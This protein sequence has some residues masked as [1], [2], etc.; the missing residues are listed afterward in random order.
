M[1]VTTLRRAVLV[2]CLAGVGATAV[3]ATAVLAQGTAPAARIKQIRQQIE[4]A[5]DGHAVITT[6]SQIQILTAAAT[7]QLS[8]VPVNYDATLQTAEVVEAYTLKANG[9]KV[10][11]DPGNI[12]TQK[13]AQASSLVPIY[14]NAEQKMVLFP[15]VEAGDTLVLT[16]RITETKP[17]LSGQYTLSHYFSPTVEADDSVYT[18]SAPTALHL[19]TAFSGVKQDVS[20]EGDRTIYRW[21]LS[22]IAT[23]AAPANLV[24]D[25]ASEAHF[26]VS[27]F[28]DYDAFVHDYAQR[29]AG[30]VEATPPVARQADQL[31]T[32]IRDKRDQARALYQWMN[33]NVRYVAIEFGVGSVIPHDPDWTLNNGFGDCK[34][35]AVLFASMLAAKGIKAELVLI[36]ATNRYTLTGTPTVGEFN[37]MIVYLPEFNLYADTTVPGL[38]FGMLPL[39][40]YGRPVMHVVDSGPAQHKTPLLAAGQ[41]TSTYK[42]HA[43]QNAQG[44][45]DADMNV[46]ATGP[47]AGSL[48]RIGGDIS[49]L[50]GAAAAGALLKAHGFPNATGTLDTGSGSDAQYILNGTYH[51][52]R[53]NP[54]ANLVNIANGLYIL[55]RAGDFL[56][57]PLNNKT[58]TAGDATPCFSGK[59]IE[60]ISFQF[61]GNAHLQATPADVHVKTASASYDSHWTVNGS[62]ATLHREFSANLDQAFCSDKVRADMMGLL[63][64]IRD[65]YDVPTRIAMGGTAN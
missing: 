30:K 22:N 34:D 42:V 18:I 39:P 27:S 5:P 45:F 50:G 44:G 41:L 60:D 23:K 16:S 64:Q 24:F 4:V 47:W 11:V 52:G 3:L 2:A 13:P 19:N 9:D 58:I 54:Q 26:L 8:Q 20:T 62:S 31:T 40:D 6:T 63:A 14:S 10:M 32:G 65:D 35:Q 53:P 7:T 38:S 59:Q 25:P 46:T 61:A 21:S 43:V 1:I 55:P 33:Q 56:G 12:L 17:F 51:T 29:I 48:R 37:H 15:R 28:K 36:N 49:K 57:G